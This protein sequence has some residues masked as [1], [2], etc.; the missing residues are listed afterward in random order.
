MKL[1]CFVKVHVL[2]ADIPLKKA[3]AGVRVGL[4]PEVGFMVNPTVQQMEESTLDLIMAGTD[5]AVL[6]IEGYCDFLTEAQMLEAIAVGSEAIGNLCRSIAAWAKKVGKTKL[7]AE[8]DDIQPIIDS[9]QAAMGSR[10][11]EVYRTP[12]LKQERGMQIEAIRE[13][14]FQAFAAHQRPESELVSTAIGAAAASLG[15][16]GG[17]GP[18]TSKPSAYLD[19]NAADEK[20]SDTVVEPP[21][22]PPDTAANERAASSIGDMPS[23]SPPE[24]DEESQSSSG[25]QI[26]GARSIAKPIVETGLGAAA[27]GL[28]GVGGLGKS[29]SKPDKGEE[30]AGVS[31]RVLPMGSIA[32]TPAQVSRALKEVASKATRR[33]VLEEGYRVDGRGVTDVRPI[34]SRAGCLPRV[35]GSALFTRGETQALAVTTL[36]SD[37]AAQRQDSMSEDYATGKVNFY[38]QYFFPPSSVGETGRTGGMPGRREVGHGMLAQ[39]ALAPI[40]PDE[41][42][43]L[44]PVRLHGWHGGPKVRLCVS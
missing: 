5:S 37:A 14:V 18:S 16:V 12:Q 36:G 38:L 15:G 43:L 11:E 23:V 6:M 40:V 25:Q 29:N 26:P 33:L 10:F 27:M 19:V 4:L 9:I 39:R 30:E 3:V 32:A 31:G 42:K 21:T 44:F 8:A 22:D 17:L 7:D 24:E 35:H 34:W 28:G 2:P 20:T 41:V 1:V 13:E